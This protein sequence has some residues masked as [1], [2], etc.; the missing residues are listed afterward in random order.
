MEGSHTLHN[1]SREPWIDRQKKNPPGPLTRSLEGFCSEVW[2]A[3][4]FKG[5]LKCLLVPFFGL[6]SGQ[7]NEEREM[8]QQSVEIIK[9]F[10]NLCSDFGLRKVR[11]VVC[12]G[13]IGPATF[14]DVGINFLNALVIKKEPHE[15]MGSFSV[16][17]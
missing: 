2:V 12:A 13:A 15:N 8:R 14:S 10:Y 6:A 4:G 11:V 5:N 3:V 7:T 1:S 17:C 9:R 16:F